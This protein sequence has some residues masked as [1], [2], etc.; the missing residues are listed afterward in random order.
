[1]SRHISRRTALQ[2]AAALA[3]WGIAPPGATAHAEPAPAGGTALGAGVDAAGPE[4]AHYY[5]FQEIAEGR[6]LVESATGWNF[7][8]PPVPFDPDGV[9][10]VVD[11]PD[12]A[13]L[14]PGSPQRAASEACDRAYTDMLLGLQRVF[15]GHPEELHRVS[16]MMFVLGNQARN[17]LTVP[18][19]PGARTVLGPAFQ[20]FEGAPSGS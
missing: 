17:L 11:N 20:W 16:A 12:T 10:P 3:A 15:D 14:P 19:A 6:R 7:D 13:A 1:M 2:A 18:S 8:G 9:H 4:L 5:R